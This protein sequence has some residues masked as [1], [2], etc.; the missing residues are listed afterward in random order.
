MIHFLFYLD[1][2]KDTSR[3][4]Q[5]NWVDTPISKPEL[6]SYSVTQFAH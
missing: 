6:N 5:L 3:V 4:W 2:E 1:E